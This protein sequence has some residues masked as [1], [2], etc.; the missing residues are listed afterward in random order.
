MLDINPIQLLRKRE[1]SFLPAHF[2]TIKIDRFILD[3][4]MEKWIKTRLKGRYCITQKPMISD[5]NKVKIFDIIG[6]EDQKELTFFMLA[7]PFFRRTI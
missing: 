4:N 1:M 5:D 7:C 2:S 6:F 3:E